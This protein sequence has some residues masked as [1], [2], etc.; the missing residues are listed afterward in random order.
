MRP[1][2]HL[3][4]ALRIH[5]SDHAFKALQLFP[6]FETEV[7][8]E[9]YVKVRTLLIFNSKDVRQRRVVTVMYEWSSGQHTA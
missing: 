4:V 5:L 6:G 2:I 7:R 8:G 1:L 3:Y 9:T